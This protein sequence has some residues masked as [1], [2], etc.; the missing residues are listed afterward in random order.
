MPILI[1]LSPPPLPSFSLIIFFV[2]NATA[3]FLVQVT[4]AILDSFEVVDVDGKKA[5][6]VQKV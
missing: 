6:Y 1:S 2:F 3:L 4:Y 5:I